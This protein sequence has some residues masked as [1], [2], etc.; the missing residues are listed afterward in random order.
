MT[1]QGTQPIAVKGKAMQV[2][3]PES[4]KLVAT[5]ALAVIAARTLN[6]ETAIVA[7]V[8]CGGLV[9]TW[10]WAIRSRLANWSVLKFLANQVTDD[11]AFVRGKK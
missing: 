1:D 5:A 10:A 4:F 9:A 7:V 3:A 11:V 2:V 6:S 8:A